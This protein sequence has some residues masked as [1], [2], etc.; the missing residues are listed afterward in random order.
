MKV[1]VGD[2]IYDAHDEPVMVILSEMDKQNIINMA[3]WATK[4]CAFPEETDKDFVR[5]WMEEEPG[6]G[7]GKDS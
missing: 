6:D 5:E 1:K 2:T 7:T 3:P 4:Y